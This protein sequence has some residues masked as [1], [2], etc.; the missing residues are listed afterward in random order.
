MA[1][2][3]CQSCRST[4]E[5]RPNRRYC[6]VSCRR[7]AEM[8]QREIKKEERRQTMLSTMNPDERAFYD[9]CRAWEGSLPKTEDLWPDL[10][11][12]EPEPGPVKPKPS[13]A[14]A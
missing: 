3:T 12:W 14:G 2:L 7:A 6:S 4:F 8:A 9:S 13:G 11:P 5:G 1:T 10:K